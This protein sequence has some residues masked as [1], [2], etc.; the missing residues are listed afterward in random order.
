MRPVRPPLQGGSP[1]SGSL[2]AMSVETLLKVI[3]TSLWARSPAAV[4][5][6]TAAWVEQNR[7][8][9]EE[10]TAWPVRARLREA[11]PWLRCPT[12]LLRRLGL[13]AGLVQGHEVPVGPSPR[14]LGIEASLAAPRSLT[15]ERGPAAMGCD[16]Y[17]TA[18]G[19]DDVVV[20]ARTA[21]GDRTIR[22]WDGIS[23]HPLRELGYADRV[24]AIAASDGMI[25]VGGYSN[26]YTSSP[27]RIK[28]W[29][30][31]S[32][33]CLR[34][35]S[36]GQQ[37]PTRVAVDDRTIACTS[38]GLGERA[39]TVWDRASGRRL[40]WAPR[41]LDFTCVAVHGDTI[42]GGTQRSREIHLWDRDSGQT[43]QT[44]TGHA[45]HVTCIAIQNDVIV[46]GSSDR[47][48]KVWERASGQ[49]LQTLVGHHF[50]VT[51]VTILDD[52]IVSGSSDGTV[53]VWD[54]TSGRCLQTLTE[55]AAAA[56]FV[57]ARDGGIVSAST[58]GAVKVW[59]AAEALRAIRAQ[60]SNTKGAMGEGPSGAGAH[61]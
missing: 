39:L 51:A 6:L 15:V 46:S 41:G 53:K 57:A 22:V 4:L 45:G 34:T 35:L 20:R 27:G 37:W 43:L 32:D 31:E 5:T 60:L 12:S 47:T 1:P 16:E 13:P 40:Q 58:D 61:L 42:A 54:R 38:R 19:S 3:G 24:C 21:Y 28:I 33:V 50:S 18:L 2:R 29:N 23:G 7:P 17:V 14:T 30:L 36:L 49:C 8:P 10:L 44:L 52:R 59:G 11:Y 25:I 9:D 26:G 48:V 55:H 56:N